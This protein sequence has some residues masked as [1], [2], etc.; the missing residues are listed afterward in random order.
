MIL[1][2]GFNG[3][4][5]FLTG[6][7]VTGGGMSA[8]LLSGR[9]TARMARRYL[10]EGASVPVINGGDGTHEY[11]IYPPGLGEPYRSR[12]HKAGEDL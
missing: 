9:N 8:A 12:R 2:V 7:W 1:D 4:N 5:L 3:T 10:A 11:D 6:A